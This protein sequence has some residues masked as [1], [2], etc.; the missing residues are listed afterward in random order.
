MLATDFGGTSLLEALDQS[1]DAVRLFA[2]IQI[3]CS[4]RNDRW[5]ELG[6]PDRRL[7]TL[8]RDLERMLTDSRA[9]Q[10][11]TASGLDERDR[12]ALI[13]ATPCLTDLCHQVAEGSIPQT[14][15]HWDFR[16]GNIRVIEND[17]LFYDW[18]Q[19]VI[20]H[21]FFSIARFMEIP[22]L[23]EEQ[24]QAVGE[25]YL[26]PW[27][28]YRPMESLRETL[29]RVRRLNVAFGRIRLYHELQHWDATSVEAREL[30]AGL[31][32]GLRHI[33]QMLESEG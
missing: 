28:T 12:D 17:F 1:Q 21:P 3:D 24:R 7:E 8:P 20:S 30:W 2:R 6:C 32:S 4:V 22:W 10:P 15:V 23:T 13:R 19:T 26:E 25:A 18:G 16:P 27:A 5:V 29:Q 31:P 11:H 33:R 9:M 14:L